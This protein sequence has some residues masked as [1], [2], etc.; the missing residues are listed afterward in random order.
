MPIRLQASVAGA[1]QQAFNKKYFLAIVLDAQLTL[2]WPASATLLQ[3]YHISQY[4]W[5]C[6]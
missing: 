5:C 2:S 4:I 6:L 3:A 1:G